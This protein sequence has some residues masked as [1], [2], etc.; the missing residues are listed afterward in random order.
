MKD[1]TTIDPMDFI[2]TT[3]STTTTRGSTTKTTS[4]KKDSTTKTT[5]PT[6][7]MPNSN[8]TGMNTPERSVC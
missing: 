1:S 2:T 3:A 7:R 4:P 5:K 6:T 8:P